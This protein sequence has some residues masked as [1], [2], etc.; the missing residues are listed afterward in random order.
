VGHLKLG[1]PSLVSS[2]NN[3][4]FIFFF[5]LLLKGLLGILLPKGFGRSLFFGGGGGGVT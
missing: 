4:N 1:S 3:R 5:F 2:Y